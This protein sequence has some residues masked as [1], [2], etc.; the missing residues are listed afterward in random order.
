M[1]YA[2]KEG[3]DIIFK[4]INPVHADLKESLNK[5]VPYIVDITEQ[6]EAGYINWERPE[7]CL[8]DEFFKKFNVTG[9]SIGGDSSFEVCVLTGKRTLMTSK[10]LNLCSPGIGFD[11]DNESY[12][13]C[14]EFRDAVYSFLYEAELYVTENKCSEI[15]REFDFKDGEDPFEHVDDAEEAITDDDNNEMPSTIE[16]QELVLET[17]S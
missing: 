5:L 1:V 3:N 8:E 13:H 7:S 6:K 2:D 12:M 16:H 14:E 10:V 4:G 15:Q 17:A 11:P 9:V